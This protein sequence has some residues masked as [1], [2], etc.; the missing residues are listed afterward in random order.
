MAPHNDDSRRGSSRAICGALLDE[1]AN[2]DRVRQVDVLIAEVW[3][4]RGE[5]KI[6][7]R[8]TDKDVVTKNY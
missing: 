7:Q 8:F 6:T 4:A 3:Q 1:V 2:D 5:D